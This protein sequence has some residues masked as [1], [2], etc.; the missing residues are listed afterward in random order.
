MYERI[1]VG[2][3]L[4]GYF[5]TTSANDVLTTGVSPAHSPQ[6]RT[7]NTSPKVPPTMRDEEAAVT[8]R[9]P[10]DPGAK[11][12][13]NQIIHPF[14]EPVIILIIFAVM[15]GIIGT[16]LLISFCIRRLVK[17]SPPV[18]KPVSLEDTDLPL[19]SAEMGQTAPASNP[20]TE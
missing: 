11:L 8:T 3:L 10:S 1:T 6:A 18:I 5:L 7:V 16:I 20:S 4:S 2:L 17:K 19:S 13:R 15:F 14:S 12:G 9:D